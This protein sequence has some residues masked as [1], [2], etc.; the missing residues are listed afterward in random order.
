MLRTP[1]EGSDASLRR[2]RKMTMNAQSDTRTVPSTT[3]APTRKLPT[4]PLAR[5]A[6]TDCGDGSCGCGCGLPI[7]R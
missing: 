2:D 4:L 3:K 6:N 1:P 7:S 5:V